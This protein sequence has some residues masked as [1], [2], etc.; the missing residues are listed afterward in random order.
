MWLTLRHFR[1]LCRGL[2]GLTLRAML[3]D[4]VAY[5][6]PTAVEASHRARNPNGLNHHAN[7]R[8]LVEDEQSWLGR[9]WLAF[10]LLDC[11]WCLVLL[12]TIEAEIAILVIELTKGI[13]FV[14]WRVT[15]RT[16][17]VIEGGVETASVVELDLVARHP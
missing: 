17:R 14:N 10:V 3:R 4:R 12:E 16:L 1:F 15:L 8:G 9:T 6:Y 11:G 13:A 7:S 2:C 5:R